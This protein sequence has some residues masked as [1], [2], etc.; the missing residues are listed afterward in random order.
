MAVTIDAVFR[1]GL[2]A[3]N[4]EWSAAI[5]QL[6]QTLSGLCKWAPL[7][8]LTHAVIAVF[9]VASSLLFGATIDALIGAR[10]VG[11]MTSD[12][13]TDLWRFGGL[14]LAVFVSYLFTMKF[15]GLAAASGLAIE[16]FLASSLLLIALAW[17]VQ[18]A[19]I[20]T[21]ILAH[22][23]LSMYGAKLYIRLAILTLV[24]VAVIVTINSSLNFT[25]TRSITV[26][27][28]LT[29]IALVAW[30]AVI[31]KLRLLRTS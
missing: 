19:F 7:F 16:G 6:R 15:S 12:L 30:S 26:G 20:A 2:I 31:L 11:V 9:P 5:R 21:L 13:T 23:L 17:S 8:V 4:A 18:W 22:L 27:E 25:V 28:G 10:G 29:V 3:A 1:D 24:L 14:I